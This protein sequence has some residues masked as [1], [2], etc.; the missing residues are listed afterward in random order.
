V[1]KTALKPIATGS[2]PE[3]VGLDEKSFSELPMHKLPLELEFTPLKLLALSLP[4]LGI[5]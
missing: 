4:P 1:K 3:A 5:F 2:L